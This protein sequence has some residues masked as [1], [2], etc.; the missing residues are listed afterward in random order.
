MGVWAKGL[1]VQAL[2]GIP[3]QRKD[4]EARGVLS[5]RH[6]CPRLFGMRLKRIS[7]FLVSLTAAALTCI[8]L[9]YN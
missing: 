5:Y 1:E 3:G 6:L 8:A 7:Y 9:S 2:Q 4:T